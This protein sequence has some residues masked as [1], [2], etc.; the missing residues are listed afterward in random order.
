MASRTSLPS[1]PHDAVDLPAMRH[2]V[3]ADLDDAMIPLRSGSPP[4]GVAQVALPIVDVA[5]RVRVDQGWRRQFTTPRSL[6][7][8]AAALALAFSRASEVVS[9]PPLLLTAWFQIDDAARAAEPSVAAATTVTSISRA[10]VALALRS[11][12]RPRR[13][14]PRQSPGHLC[15]H[16]GVAARHH[17]RGQ[18]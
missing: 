1:L 11:S 13:R 2:G 12:V 6:I 9:L 10:H 3:A 5:P 7:D 15:A 18:K 4:P 16:L 8:N 14:R 17:A